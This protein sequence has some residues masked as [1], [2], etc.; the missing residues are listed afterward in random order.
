LWTGINASILQAFAASLGGA[1][2]REQAINELKEAKREAESA[3]KSKSEF[4]ANMS[5]EIR[6]PLNAV[7]GLTGLLLKTDLTQE[8]RDYADTIR[9]SGESL[10]SVINDI[11][12]FSKIDVG[13]MNLEQ[14][15]FSLIDC[16]Q[17]S[18]DLVASTASEKGINLSFE[19]DPGTP[20]MIIGDPSKLRQILVNLL[21]N[22]IKFTEKGDVKLSSISRKCNG[23]DYEIHFVIEDTGIGI[24]QEKMSQLFESFSQVDPSITRRY[25]GTGLGLAISKRLVE[26][27][28]GSIWAESEVSK[29][30]IFHFTIIAGAATGKQAASVLPIQLPILNKCSTDRYPLRILLAEDNAI[31]Q[32]VAL[33]M[34]KK[35]GYEADVAANGLEVL[36]AME[37]QPYDLILMDIQMPVMD[38]IEAA[39]NIRERWKNVPKIIAITAYALEGDRERCI[40]AG[41]ND[42]ISKPIQIEELQNKIDSLH[43]D[44]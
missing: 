42:Y 6:T 12:D 27:M 3:G 44:L 37:L 8:Q 35:I 11:L 40:K 7:I 19:I 21:N 38:G 34:L 31:N 20:E 32:K 9:K 4:L 2:I 29:G 14:Q 22:A 5:H 23:E 26:L 16:I 43:I 17:E 33:Q 15:S 24:P 1:I 18:L 41:M 10:L 30:S 39:R 13:K 36:S 28:G 25:G